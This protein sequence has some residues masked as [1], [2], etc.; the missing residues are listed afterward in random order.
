MDYEQ[1]LY[2][3]DAGVATVTLNRPEHRNALSGQMLGELVDAMTRVRDDGDV[4]A[5]VLTGA[6][7]KVFCAGADLK[8]IE[9]FAGRRDSEAGPFG[10]TRLTPSKPTIAAISGWCLAGGLELA[11]WCDLRVVTSESNFGY[12]E[13]RFGVLDHVPCRVL[14][15]WRAHSRC[16]GPLAGE[17]DREAHVISARETL[18]F[19]LRASRVGYIF[20]TSRWRGGVHSRLRGCQ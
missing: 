15:P 20:M 5:V 11:L 19:R 10:F 9:S 17:D 3:V 14:A 6:G 12:T 4:R 18:R 16:L 8:A 2:E 7:E 1:L 13:R